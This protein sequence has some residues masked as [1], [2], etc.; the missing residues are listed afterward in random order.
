LI[1]AIPGFA[2]PFSSLSHLLP[3]AVFTG[4]GIALLLRA[5]GSAVRMASLAVYVF[6]CVFLLAMSGVFHLLDPGGMP[7]QVLQRLD[8]A[9]IFIQI[10]GTFTP[11]HILLFRGFWRWG[12]LALVWGL[13]IAGLT[14]KSIYFDQLPESLGL[15]MYLGLGW[16]GILSAVALYRWHGTRFLKPL[17]WG[18]VAFTA[19]AVIDF[20]HP[21]EVV[22]G[23]IGGHELFHVAVLFGM[24]FHWLLIEKVVR[25]HRLAPAGQMTPEPVRLPAR[26]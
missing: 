25:Y 20:L 9:A 22:P 18:A 10:A 2:E 5:R 13:A 4:L 15:L 17:I 26:S 24:G 19:G 6:A 7:R 12:I 1:Q 23:V 8:H 21:P 11:L 14:L 16:M 3:T